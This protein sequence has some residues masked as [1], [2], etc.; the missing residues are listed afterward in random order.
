MRGEAACKQVSMMRELAVEVAPLDIVDS[1]L[2]VE[3]GGRVL[4]WK[5]EEWR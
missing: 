4:R 1:T 5:G 3:P 2:A